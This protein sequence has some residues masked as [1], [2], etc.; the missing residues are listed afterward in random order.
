M[1]EILIGR[2]CRVSPGSVFCS[3]LTNRHS[4]N[5]NRS[6]GYSDGVIRTD[7]FS[8]VPGN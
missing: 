1:M 5:C 2:F 4:E 3:F 6:G 8:T 7:R